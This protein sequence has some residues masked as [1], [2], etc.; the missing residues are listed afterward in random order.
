LEDSIGLL[1]A[2]LISTV[3]ED[4]APWRVMY[5]WETCRGKLLE[6]GGSA[7]TGNGQVVQ[8]IG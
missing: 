4:L 7:L 6:C 8:P 2:R 3:N 5:M 1:L